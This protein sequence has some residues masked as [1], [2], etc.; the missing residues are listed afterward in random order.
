MEQGEIG[1]TFNKNMKRTFVIF[2]PF[3]GRELLPLES[4]SGDQF[5]M[6]LANKFT[7]GN[8]PPIFEG[9]YE[10]ATDERRSLNDIL[11]ELKS[12]S[13]IDPRDTLKILRGDIVSI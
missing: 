10:I 5:R 8:M 6:Y 11:E 12:P 2:N 13:L 1:K 4:I 9:V 7:D 3:Q